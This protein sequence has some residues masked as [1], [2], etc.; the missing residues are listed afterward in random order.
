MQPS[1]FLEQAILSCLKHH[2]G[3]TIS[4]LSPLE[5]GADLEAAVY[6]AKTLTKATYF[7]KLTRSNSQDLGTR[8]VEALSQTG[9][10]HLVPALKTQKGEQ[11][12]PVGDY[13]LSVFPFIQGQSGFHRQLS[14]KQWY[15]LGKALRQMHET[16]LPDSLVL[17]LPQVSHTPRWRQAVREIIPLLDKKLS[18]DRVG[19]DFQG[20]M[21]QQLALIK[22]LLDQAEVLAQQVH[23]LVVP[24]VLCHGDIHA[25][26]V[27]IDEK[28]HFYIVDWDTPLLA[29]KE[30]DLMF[31]GGG[32]GN[33]WNKPEEAVLFYQVF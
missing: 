12:K 4:D 19:M 31:I 17:E 21:K 9:L 23:P 5:V 8:V 15:S 11:I 13:T 30:R 1:S 7:V 2:W 6:R 18:G 14:Q 10:S 32:V 20:F 22:W 26:N 24:S 16:P 3:I 25:G 29:P 33:V 27:L 28:D